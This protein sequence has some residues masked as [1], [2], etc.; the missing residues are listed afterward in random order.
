MKPYK[1]FKEEKLVVTKN[2]KKQNVYNE[3]FC[4]DIET[5]S[6]FII[7]GK[8]NPF[9]YDKP[10]TYYED[11]EK[12]CFMYIWQ[13]GI[14]DTV[15]YGRTWEEFL[16]FMELLNSV[17]PH[18]KIVYVHNLSY[19]F[20]YL[21]NVIDCD[22]KPFAR[23]PHKVMKFNWDIYNI[24]MRCSYAL[25]NMSLETLADSYKL[26]VKKQTG[27]LDYTTLHF[28][29]TELTDKELLYCKYD[30]LVMYHYLL[31]HKEHYKNIYDIP[32][33]Q[34]GEVRREVKKL[35]KNDSNY[36]RKVWQLVPRD[37]FMFKLLL[38]VFAG[39]YTH[40]NY[41]HTGDILENVKSK[42]LSSSYPASMCA[43]KYPMG[44][45]IKLRSTDINVS[46]ETYK[47]N[48]FIFDL[49]FEDIDCQTFNTFISASKCTNVRKSVVDNGRLRSA[50]TI[51]I[52]VTD[53][54]FS[55]IEN[56]YTWKTLKVNAIYTAKK[57]YLDKRYILKILELFGGKTTLKGI[58]ESESLYMKMKQ[59]I[60]SLY[61]MMVTNII[62][63][64]VIFEN[65]EWNVEKITIDGINA[66]LDKQRNSRNTFLA[67]QWGVWV[68][69]YSRFAL[70]QAIQT[71][72]YDVLYCD[73]D[74]VKYVG[75][76]EDFF[77]EYNENI[78]SRL[79]EMCKHYNIDE[80]ML[81]PKDQN[82][83]EH[84]IGVFDKEPTYTQFKTLGAKKYIGEIEK[85]GKRILKMTVSG[86]S[87]K[88]VHSL[89][90][91]DDFCCGHVF[92]YKESGRLIMTYS[93]DFPLIHYKDDTGEHAINDCK[94][95]IHAMPTTYS[96]DISD[97]YEDF[98][99]LSKS[100]VTATIL[101]KG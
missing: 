46:R 25:S 96:M 91:I 80:N 59:F 39:G 62:S 86:V 71:I 3:I 61:G 4:F 38:E 99:E 18:K 8:L 58:E 36:Y 48:C 40:A 79:R 34:T 87:K 27:N 82:G 32:L 47:D 1:E 63:D 30:I 95:G 52:K 73:T 72:D 17:Y 16:E 88:A 33:T 43:F 97:E 89:N 23:K 57:D 75:E 67:F 55:I 69:A 93:N 60:N 19:E 45:F 31:R 100:C 12:F 28:P 90:S 49:T 2:R 35:F 74:S 84:W 21:L 41:I 29:T 98:L 14:N 20:Q 68:T 9:D 76:H 7:G 77:T 15:Y 42:D 92:G 54:D 78:K 81:H 65:G 13:F 53:V 101:E 64:E 51:S 70:W 85:D 83:T 22:I 94:Y 37:S 6:G 11:K 56:T 5:T 50:E 26:P 44:Q 24:E 10:K 66:K